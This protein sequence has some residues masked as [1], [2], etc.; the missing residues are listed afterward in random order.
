M[1]RTRRGVHDGVAGVLSPGDKAPPFTLLDQSGNKVKL[2]D[3]K[4]HKV[5]VYFYPER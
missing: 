2:S 1:L 4:G 5:L 3:F